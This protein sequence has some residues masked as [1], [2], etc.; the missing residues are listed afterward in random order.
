MM[1]STT[2]KSTFPETLGGHHKIISPNSS[3]VKQPQDTERCIYVVQEYNCA[4]H[5]S[6][7]NPH[8]FHRTPCPQALLPAASQTDCENY[9][10][11]ENELVQVSRYVMDRG[12]MECKNSA[13]RH[14]REETV[15]HPEI[16]RR[17]QEL[18]L[19][20]EDIDHF[21]KVTSSFPA[22]K[23]VLELVREREKNERLR[24][25]ETRCLL[26]REEGKDEPQNMI[27]AKQES[28]I[29]FKMD[30]VEVIPPATPA[31][32]GDA[33]VKGNDSARV[34]KEHETTQTELM[35]TKA[36]N[37]QRT[38]T[39]MKKSTSQVSTKSTALE[40]PTASIAL[41]I[42]QRDE[43]TQPQLRNPAAK[44]NLPQPPTNPI[45]PNNPTPNISP[46]KKLP[47]T[48]PPSLPLA[49]PIPSA[50]PTP[51]SPKS[52]TRQTHL[53]EETARLTP[54]K[55]TD[56][57]HLDLDA[58]W[59]TDLDEERERV[60]GEVALAPSFGCQ[61]GDEWIVVGSWEQ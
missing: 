15:K 21:E 10:Q 25:D 52:Q 49:S 40:N 5:P 50:N 56:N 60:F 18:G 12:C 46:T 24:R 45:T 6:L 35:A 17:M 59:E 11:H 48:E 27:E 4:H 58:E 44:E 32:I 30:N 38:G 8:I 54:E 23:R 47:T 28:K 39:L 41:K 3:S 43:L 51:P 61:T 16:L 26:L 13:R 1:S 33:I 57:I 20:Q 19:G 2:A 37:P 22:S 7:N 55:L 29:Q 34:E 9:A 42:I 36:K 14:R 53:A 31:L